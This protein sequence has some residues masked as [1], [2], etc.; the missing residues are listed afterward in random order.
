MLVPALARLRE[1]R[2][3]VHVLI[4][5]DTGDLY[6]E[7][8]QHCLKLATE[9][10][11]ADRL[12][13]LGWVRDEELPALYRAADLFVGGQ[14]AALLLADGELRVAF[15]AY[16][17]ADVRRMVETTA[18]GFYGFDLDALRPIGDRV[19]PLVADVSRPLDLEDWP[20]KTTCNA[21]DP[22]QIL[23]AW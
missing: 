4:A 2:P 1:R 17:E 7:E 22:T 14:T 20:T 18:A 13:F 16:A 6:R 23:R 3:E 10:G 12:H 19:G 9:L 5:G 21:F 15:A 8:H 11:V